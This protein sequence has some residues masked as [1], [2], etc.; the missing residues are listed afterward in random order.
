ML[1]RQRGG[2]VSMAVSFINERD[3]EFV[4]YE[5]LEAVSLTSYPRFADH[6][7]ETFDAVRK[8]ARDIARDRF[9]P[10]NRKAD[11]NEPRL[12]D[13]RVVH[14][15]EV[16]AALEAYAKA[17]FLSAHMDYDRGGMQL[18]WIVSQACMAYFQAA[19]VGTI[20]YPFLTMAAA[21][22]LNAFGTEEQKRLYLEPM[23]DGRFFG[24]MVLT[25]P[26]VGSSLSDVSTSA[27]PTDDG[28]YLL[29]GTKMF[30][31]GGDHELAE[32]IVHLVLARIAG[33]PPGAKGLSL[34]LVPRFVM[35]AD[36]TRGPRND[37][38][39]A[40]LVHKM[41][42]RGTVST[43]LKFGEKG[44]CVGYLVG[45]PQQGLACMF[46]MMNEA[47]IGVGMGAVMLGYAGYRQSLDYARSRPQ[48]RPPAEKDPTKRPVMLIEHA[49]IKRML[50]AQKA[51]VE[52]A[53]SL[54]LYCSRLVDEKASAPDTSA[55]RDAALLLEI[56][57][58]IMKA[59]PSDWCLEANKL[60]IQIHGGY[61]YTRDYPVEQHYRDNRLNPIHE[62]TNGIQAIDLLG[63]KVGIENGAAFT[64][65]MTKM[66]VTAANA[67]RSAALAEFG[68]ALE[69]AIA[70]VRATTAALVAV[71]DAGNINL[72]LANA[73]VYLDMLGH[74]VLAWIW[75]KQALVAERG[76]GGA[77]ADFYAGKIA[78]CRYFMRWEL[79][80][81]RAQGDLLRRLDATCLEMR[82][83]L[84]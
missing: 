73:S 45:Q 39:L 10:H 70:D 23:L 50:L 36:G 53:F 58:P 62:G 68:G 8:T 1:D 63:R 13:G 9:Q 5:L 18:P 81:T 78:A 48:G 67:R 75:L 11:E 57:T 59:W 60:A 16:K 84:F 44:R 40:G 79:P 71:R 61:G 26:E 37:V 24:T 27:R 14:I 21:N 66:T 38:A 28:H 46:H 25:E 4:L 7:R 41:G 31:S 56:L 77:E 12:V 80:K 74:V 17:G 15:P 64:L 83:E 20:A 32:N 2:A 52:G 22:L 29:S 51:Y 55:R 69:S 43:I 35:N 72:F 49:D 82:D 33:A 19:N 65:L 3:V 54:G 30:I 6:N 34:F 76:L 47:R 42:Y